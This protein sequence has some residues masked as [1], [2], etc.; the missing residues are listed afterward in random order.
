MCGDAGRRQSV[1]KLIV[2]PAA[3]GLRSL[4][5]DPATED[6]KWGHDGGDNGVPPGRAGAEHADCSGKD[7]EIADGVISRTDPDRT[8]IR[9]PLPAEAEERDGNANVGSAISPA[10]SMNSGCRKVPAKACHAVFPPTHAPKASNVTPLTRAARAA[11]RARNSHAQADRAIGRVAENI[12]A[13]AC[14]DTRHHAHTHFQ[15][16]HAGV[17]R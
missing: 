12:K 17:D 1:P 11:N 15:E 16:E 7:G 2:V 4:I 8:H 3:P 6:P 14:S 5:C 9:V 10:P 13:P